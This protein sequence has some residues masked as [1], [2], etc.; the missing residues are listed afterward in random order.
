MRKFLTLSAV[1]LVLLGMISVAFADSFRER[2]HNQQ[3]RIDQGIASGQLTRQEADTL[4]DNL[5]WIKYEFARMTDDGKLTPAE[6]KRLDDLL[7]RNN[8]MIINK[9]H[10]PVTVFYTKKIGVGEFIVDRIKNQQA[11]IDQGIRSK[12]LTRGEADIL[13]DNLNRIRDDFHHFKKGGN[14]WKEADRLDRMLDRNSE[15]IYAKK[16]NTNV[17]IQRLDFKLFMNF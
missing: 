4:Q 5:S 10:N 11:R 8:N 9:K 1:V 3:K 14:N 6:S 2:I 16:H 7:D 12:E 15:M 17:P 13:M